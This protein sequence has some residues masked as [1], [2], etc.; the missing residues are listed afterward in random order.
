MNLDQEEEEEEDSKKPT[1]RRKVTTRYHY[2]CVSVI[3]CHDLTFVLY[4]CFFLN[5]FTICFL[6]RQVKVEVQLTL[7]KT[8]YV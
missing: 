1:K 2:V 5:I 8:L 7:T 6:V 4:Q 3:R